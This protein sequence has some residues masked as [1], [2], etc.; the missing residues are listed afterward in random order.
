[1]RRVELRWDMA[2][3][4]VLAKIVGFLRAGH[5]EGVPDG[6][7]IPLVARLRRRLAAVGWPVSDPFGSPA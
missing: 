3:S 5:P 7:Y 1:L 4:D 6:G 2:L